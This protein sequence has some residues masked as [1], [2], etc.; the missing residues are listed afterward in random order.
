MFG[1]GVLIIVV[2]FVASFSIYQLNL[3]RSVMSTTDNFNY[4]YTR[5]VVHE[6]ALTAMNFGVNKVWADNT[7]NAN[8]Q[9]VA[10][11]CT[12]QVQIYEVGLDTV[13]VC[14]N[15]W[16]HAFDNE[17]YA[18]HNK[19]KKVQDS[20]VA[21]FSYKQPISRYFWFTNHEA[22]VYWISQ[23]TVWGPIHTNH[24]LNTN[25]D[26]VFYG[27]VT[28]YKG[29]APNPTAKGCKAKFYGG[30]EVGIKNEVP[31]DMS[32]LINAATTGNGGAA[33]N[34]KSLY[35]TE[36]TFE[37][38]SNGDII[39]TVGAGVADTVSLTDIAPTGVIYSSKDV[40][41]KGTLNG[42]LTIY[43]DDDI[44]ID[45]NLHYAIDPKV[46]PTSED[47][48]GLVA[49]DNVVITNNSANNSDVV[50][51]ASIMAV[52]GSFTAQDYSGRPVAG[53]IHL[54]GSVMQNNRGPVGT[55]SSWS[56][57]ITHGFSKRYYFD[58]RLSSI[59]APYYPYVRNLHLVS[60]WE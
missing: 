26:P 48:L 16:G 7:T 1:K 5:T 23:D 47:I 57:S 19:A 49:K 3:S 34:T 58:P 43:S 17:Y 10:N 6:Q 11:Q 36:T 35:N 41:V 55:F 52:N 4:Y 18:Q 53:A 37:F 21:I 60:W 22:G 25:G 59:S 51:Q 30:W 38:L 45:D 33:V 8:F 29:I 39:R 42:Q 20:V 46:D 9:I 31:T 32:P 24:I 13:R 15:T 28:A 50:I 40:H 44:F 56:G 2:G 27:K 12:S 14:S 54:T